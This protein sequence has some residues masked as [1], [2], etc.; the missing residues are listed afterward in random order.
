[1]VYGY[2]K[3]EQRPLLEAKNVA[4]DI[5]KGMKDAAITMLKKRR[6]CRSYLTLLDLFNQFF[7]PYANFSVTH[8][9]SQDYV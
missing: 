8:R 3:K 7:M 5:F 4:M 1:V 9:T 6:N 2:G